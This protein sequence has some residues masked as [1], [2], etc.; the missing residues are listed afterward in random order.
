MVSIYFSLLCWAIGCSKSVRDH[1]VLGLVARTLMTL[2]PNFVQIVQVFFL[3]MVR[4]L[5]AEVSTHA[6]G[7]PP[8]CMFNLASW[9]SQIT[10]SSSTPSILTLSIALRPDFPSFPG[11]ADMPGL[12]RCSCPPS[13]WLLF[14]ILDQGFILHPGA[15]MRDFWNVMDIT[16]VSCALTS[17]YHTVA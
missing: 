8:S 2:V 15:F 16:V 4:S 9:I 17:F 12:E 11:G 6:P 10:L 13:V 7:N 1:V 14:Q 3:R 5:E